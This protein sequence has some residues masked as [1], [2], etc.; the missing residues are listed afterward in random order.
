[1][2]L[3]GQ[4]AVIKLLCTDRIM[5]CFFAGDGAMLRWIW[6]LLLTALTACQGGRES[7][8]NALGQNAD[9]EQAIPLSVPALHGF[10]VNPYLQNPGPDRMSVMFEPTDSAIGENMAVDYRRLGDQDWA[11][12]PAAPESI[13]RLNLDAGSDLGQAVYAAHLSGLRSN[14]TYE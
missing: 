13:D 6:V 5:R 3:T 9:S 4:R 14:T 11:R 8:I 1:M 7:A 2:H 10:L 12:S